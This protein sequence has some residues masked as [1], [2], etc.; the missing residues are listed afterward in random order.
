MSAF[1][2]LTGVKHLRVRG[3]TAVRFA[4]VLK[5]LGV[6]LF[7]AAAAWTS[8]SF[9]NPEGSGAPAGEKGVFP[10]AN[11]ELVRLHAFVESV[12]RLWIGRFIRFNTPSVREQD[13]VLQQAA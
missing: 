1:D 5:A 6:N 7:R 9:G 8:R 13:F 4:V 11:S 12:L 10:R 2:R 3:F